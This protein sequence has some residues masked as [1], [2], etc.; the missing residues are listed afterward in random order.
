MAAEIEWVTGVLRVGRTFE[1]HG[2]P[3]DF[4]CTIN[5]RG[6]YAE[7]IGGNGTITPQIWR[8][9]KEALTA[10]GVTHAHWDRLN[11]APR[12]IVANSANQL[13]IQPSDVTHYALNS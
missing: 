4:S 12:S 6:D 2:D 3:Y 9:V 11:N 1:E 13:S 8:D 7:L 10:Q 5:R